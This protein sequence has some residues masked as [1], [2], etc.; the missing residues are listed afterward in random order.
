M[1][2]HFLYPVSRRKLSKPT[3]PD[4]AEDTAAEESE[5]EQKE[6]TKPKRPLGRLAL[7]KRN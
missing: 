7:R 1:Q 6:E 5:H 2:L 3:K 4:A